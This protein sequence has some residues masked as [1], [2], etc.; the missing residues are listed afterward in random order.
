MAKSPGQA[1]RDQLIIHYSTLAAANASAS[2]I[3]SI[4]GD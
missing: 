3:Y 4:P 2:A 1:D